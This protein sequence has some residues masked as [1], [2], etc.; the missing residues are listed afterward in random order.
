[1]SHKQLP[2]RPIQ[3]A[4]EVATAAF[5]SEGQVSDDVD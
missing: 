2:D 5:T 1:V 3:I 4:E